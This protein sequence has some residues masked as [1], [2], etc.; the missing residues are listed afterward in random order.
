MPT[1][2]RPMSREDLIH[3]LQDVAAKLGKR[4][5]SRAEFLR[6]TGVSEWQVIKHFDSWTGFVRSA[7]LQPHTRNV[8]L[9]DEVLL[10][11]MRDAYLAAGGIVTL[12]RFR[13][14]SRYSPDVFKKRWGGF[15]N[16][17]IRF[18]EWVI[19]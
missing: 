14:V 6:E 16:A 11:A 3:R 13:K 10:S 2:S 1:E 12:A 17:Q 19:A 8:R 9:D 18:R 15:R 7:D 4:T 5:V